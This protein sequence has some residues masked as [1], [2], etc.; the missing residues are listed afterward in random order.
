L[1]HA[2]NPR[3]RDALRLIADSGSRDGVTEQLLMAH[4]CAPAMLATLVRLGLVA[5]TI[6]FDKAG[7]KT[8]EVTRITITEAGRRALGDQ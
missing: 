3:Q 5:E 1:E 7:D 2:V 6:W 4:G 8:I